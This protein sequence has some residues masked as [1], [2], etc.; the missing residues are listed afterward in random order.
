MK[1]PSERIS[2]FGMGILANYVYITLFWNNYKFI[3]TCKRIY[4]EILHPTFFN[5]N[6]YR[7]SVISVSGMKHWYKIKGL[8]RFY[9]QYMYTLIYVHGSNFFMISQVCVT[10]TQLK[11]LIVLSQLTLFYD[12]PL[13][14]SFSFV[15]IPN[16][17]Q[18]LIG[19]P[20]STRMLLHKHLIY[21]IIVYKPLKLVFSFHST[22]F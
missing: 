5:V 8:F 13:Y 7:T 2:L 6:I 4:S 19:F 15:P 18:P 9:Q 1:R 20:F 12:T 17:W 10:T 21:E 11:Y 22:L 16:P 14:S 3:W